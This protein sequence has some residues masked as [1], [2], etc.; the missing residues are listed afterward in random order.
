MPAITAAI[1]LD[2]LL[3]SVN[4]PTLLQWQAL[5]L[6]ERCPAWEGIS[7]CHMNQWIASESGTGPGS[8]TGRVISKKFDQ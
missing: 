1:A 6:A 4:A 8:S 7:F 3:K 2:A 5:E